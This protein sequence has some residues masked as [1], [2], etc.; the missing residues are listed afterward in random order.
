MC[1][2]YNILLLKYYSPSRFVYLVYF[3]ADFCLL[4]NNECVK[5]LYLP[6]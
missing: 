2:C 4:E 3:V 6:T 5:T 1:V